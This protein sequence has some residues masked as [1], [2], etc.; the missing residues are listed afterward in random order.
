MGFSITPICVTA[1]S[2]AA[3]VSGDGAAELEVSINAALLKDVPHPNAVR[4]D[5]ERR[6]EERNLLPLVKII[7][8]D[9]KRVRELSVRPHKLCDYDVLQKPLETNKDDD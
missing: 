8:P 4:L 2:I 9:D 6:R 1:K 3:L 5:L 7:L